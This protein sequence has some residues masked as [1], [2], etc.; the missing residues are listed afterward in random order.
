MWLPARPRKAA[1][2]TLCALQVR[3]SHQERRQR[4]RARGA[5]RHWRLKHMAIDKPEEA[6]ASGRGRRAAEDPRAG[7][8][9][10]FMEVLRQPPLHWHLKALSAQPG[11]ICWPVSVHSG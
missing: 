9:E 3:K 8:L 7:D 1:T 4:R 6:P 2:L 10:R 11:S 5:Q